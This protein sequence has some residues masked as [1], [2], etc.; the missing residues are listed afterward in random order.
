MNCT[1]IILVLILLCWICTNTEGFEESA[2]IVYNEPYIN[3]KSLSDFYKIE[4]PL[5]V[6]LGKNDNNFK[7]IRLCFGSC[8]FTKYSQKFWEYVMGMYPDMWIYLGD[9]I[10]GDKVLGGDWSDSMISDDINLLTN[11]NNTYKT[12]ELNHYH[13]KFKESSIKKIGIWD[14]H[15]Y[16]R[17]NANSTN[18]LY[19]KLIVKKMLLDFIGINND[20]SVRRRQGIYTYHVLENNVTVKIILL[21]TRWFKE[22]FDILGQTQWNWLKSILLNNDS[23]INIIVSGGTVLGNNPTPENWKGCGDSQTRL[24]NFLTENKLFNTIFISGDVHASSILTNKGFVEIV[25]SPLTSPP[26]S[27]QHERNLS[28]GDLIRENNFGMLD[29]VYDDNNIVRLEQT[30]ISTVTGENIKS[31]TIN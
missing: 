3:N 25:C 27:Q 15:D 21:D 7:K 19:N 8:N 26:S 14:D 20:E 1:I 30:F 18:S 12:L 2:T 23:M 17:N 22:S 28:V 11:M 29:I 10:Y 5:S 4:R 31:Y 13:K 24:I 9:N 6:R 16:L